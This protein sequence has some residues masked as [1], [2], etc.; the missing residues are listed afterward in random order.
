MKTIIEC[1]RERVLRGARAFMVK[2]RRGEPINERA[3]TQVEK[4]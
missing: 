4:A 1:I 3:D 2:A